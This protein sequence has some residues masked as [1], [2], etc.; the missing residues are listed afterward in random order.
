MAFCETKETTIR[1]PERIVS[2]SQ[3]LAAKGFVYDGGAGW[4]VGGWCRYIKPVRSWNINR[5]DAR[6]SISGPGARWIQFS[7]RA[8]GDGRETATLAYSVTGLVRDSQ[9]EQHARDLCP[10]IRVRIHHRGPNGEHAEWMALYTDSRG[11]PKAPSVF[12]GDQL[13]TVTRF[14]QYTWHWRWANPQLAFQGFW[15]DEAN[16]IVYV[17]E[18]AFGKAGQDNSIVASEIATALSL[19]SQ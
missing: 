2:I 8:Y 13:Q 7:W 10:R 11:N 3:R 15:L 16:Q 12:E 1:D 9:R 18:P 5:P 6:A 4:Y 14:C 19:A 17:P